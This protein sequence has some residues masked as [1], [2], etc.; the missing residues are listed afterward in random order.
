M[1]TV[2]NIDSW[3]LV[4]IALE[5]LPEDQRAVKCDVL[6]PELESTDQSGRSGGWHHQWACGGPHRR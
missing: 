4:N 2:V 5:L 6:V 1:E 3:K